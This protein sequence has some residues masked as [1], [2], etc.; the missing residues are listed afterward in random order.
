MTR[1]LKFHLDLTLHATDEVPSYS[2]YHSI[3]PHLSE[4][5]SSKNAMK[6]N[7]ITL[8]LVFPNKK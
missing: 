6:Q 5:N 2:V 3:R 1:N 4:S 7:S 8:N